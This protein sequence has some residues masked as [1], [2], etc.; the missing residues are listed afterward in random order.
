[1]KEIVQLHANFKGNVQD[2]FFRQQVKAFAEEL[3]IKGYVK[4]LEDGS[5]EVIAMGNKNTL[6]KFLKKIEDKPGH[7]SISSIEK[8]FSEKGQ[9]F[10]LFEILF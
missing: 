7:G 3:N 10:D 1:M 5:V 8:S 9:S 4:N 2:V 6:E